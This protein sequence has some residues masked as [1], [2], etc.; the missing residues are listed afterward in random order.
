MSVEDDNNSIH[1]TGSLQGLN[2]MVAVKSVA[3]CLIQSK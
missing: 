1:L 2:N 3:L